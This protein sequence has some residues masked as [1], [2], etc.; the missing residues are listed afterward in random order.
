MFILLLL[1]AAVLFLIKEEAIHLFIANKEVVA[2]GAN[3]IKIFVFGMAFY[4]IFRAVVATFVGSGHNVPTMILEI[5]RL[6]GFRIPL[7]FF[8]GFVINWQATGVW[9]ALTLSNVLSAALS[10]GLF[11][12]NMWK[13]KVIGE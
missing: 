7:V 10:L 13:E 11:K 12:T 1:A 9:I 3:F 6:W 2:E 4:G 5:I 8:F